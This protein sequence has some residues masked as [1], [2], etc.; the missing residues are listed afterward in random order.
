MAG[1][2]I[3]IF[4]MDEAAT[5]KENMLRWRNAVLN[6]GKGFAWC[7]GNHDFCPAEELLELTPPWMHGAASSAAVV[8]DA[9][10]GHLALGA[11]GVIVSAIPWTGQVEPVMH[12][13]AAKNILREAK[14]LQLQKRAPFL[15]LF[16][17]PPN[18]TPLAMGHDPLE[19]DFCRR[20]IEAA[21]PDFSLHGHLHEA[22]DGRTRGWIGRIDNTICFN[23]GQSAPGEPPHYVLL[24]WRGPER[25]TAHWSGR[26]RKERVSRG[27]L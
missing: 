12:L 24:D 13:N 16:H 1:D 8:T 2:L 10:T 19:M 17:E 7:S 22:T 23:A 14:R 27:D 26:G 15:L 6:R 5:H 21:E 11:G 9:E 20:M 4:Q 18:R 3:D 25:W